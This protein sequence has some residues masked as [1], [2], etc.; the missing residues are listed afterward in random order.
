M[1]R[2]HTWIDGD[3]VTCP[4]DADTLDM[5]AYRRRPRDVTAEELELF[6]DEDPTS[7]V[8]RRVVSVG[9]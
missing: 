6:V 7:G 9:D 1:E 5:R 2:T 8:F 3:A 4:E